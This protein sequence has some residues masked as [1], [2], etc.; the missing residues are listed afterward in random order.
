[1][2]RYLATSFALAALLLCACLAATPRVLAQET[3][4]NTVLR[5][6]VLFRYKPEV[7]PEQKQQVIEAFA[8]LKNEIPT[9]LRF[10]GGPNVEVEKL[11]DGFEHVFC[12]PFPDAAA[13][14]AYLPHPAHAR[15]VQLVGPLLDKAL[16]ADFVAPA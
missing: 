15:F 8:A 10:E 2:N 14:D 4:M 1:M 7:T 12:V 16:V 5:H 9:I 6:T 13:G 11:S 3:A